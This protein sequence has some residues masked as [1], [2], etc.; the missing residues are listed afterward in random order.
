MI[1]LLK[2]DYAKLLHLASYLSQMYKNYK[3]E[4]RKREKEKKILNT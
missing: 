1:N 4:D 2:L 3:R